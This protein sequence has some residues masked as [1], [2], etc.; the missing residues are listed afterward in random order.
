MKRE[1]V[2]KKIRKASFKEIEKIL[3]FQVDQ[4][5]EEAFYD[6]QDVTE[7]E[8]LEYYIMSKKNLIYVV[9]TYLRFNTGE[10]IILFACFGLNAIDF[11][12]KRGNYLL[13]NY[14]YILQNDKI[15]DIGDADILFEE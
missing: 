7:D 3:A 11:E 1:I 2:S 15:E 8:M 13:L 10:K 4:M 14:H 6:K 5:K 9:R 12:D